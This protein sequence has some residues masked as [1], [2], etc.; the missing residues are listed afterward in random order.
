MSVALLPLAIV[1]LFAVL[2]VV[3]AFAMFF[4]ILPIAFVLGAVLRVK[5][6][7]A[8]CFAIL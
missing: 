5:D 4:A 7:F 8:M 6:A 1:L 2:T 3:D